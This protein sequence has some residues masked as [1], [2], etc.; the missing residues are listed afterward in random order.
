MKHYR[1][2]EMRRND[3]IDYGASIGVKRQ[4]SANEKGS[5]S[6]EYD[7]FAKA[8][9]ADKRPKLAD[10]QEGGARPLLPEAQADRE[11]EAMAADKDEQTAL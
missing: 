8:S 1:S 10:N 7:L 3:S 6:D 11:D 2:L 4:R 9:R 5:D